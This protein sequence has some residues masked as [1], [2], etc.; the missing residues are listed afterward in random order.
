[1]QLADWATYCFATKHHFDR[2]AVFTYTRVFTLM[3]FVEH[4]F[5]SLEALLKPVISPSVLLFN[6]PPLFSLRP[7]DLSLFSSFY[8]LLLAW[9]TSCSSC[10]THSD[11]NFAHCVIT[12][13][14]LLHL[15]ASPLPGFAYN[16][17]WEII[18]QATEKTKHTSVMYLHVPDWRYWIQPQKSVSDHL[19]K[20]ML[21]W[22][23]SWNDAI[24]SVFQ[25]DK[26][27]KTRY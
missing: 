26:T 19:K 11:N 27:R 13:D 17:S 14:P 10:F 4:Y 2:K 3:G 21:V 12:P 23:R 24:V 7:T 1:M 9:M 6:P 20:N 8:L 16:K 22:H 25:D 18:T 5:V 15:T